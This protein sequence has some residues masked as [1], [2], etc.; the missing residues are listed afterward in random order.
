MD[1]IVHESI[2]AELTNY[3][4]KI[5]SGEKLSIQLY[6]ET[7]RKYLFFLNPFGGRGKSREIWDNI[8]PIL[9]NF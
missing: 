9:S 4:Q 3:I 7:K 5:N 6:D 8:Q 1:V 2:F